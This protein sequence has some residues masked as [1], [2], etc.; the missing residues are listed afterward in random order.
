MMSGFVVCHVAAEGSQVIATKCADE[1]V[2]ADEGSK[3]L[4]Y[5]CPVLIQSSTNPCTVIMCQQWGG[6]QEADTLR[7]AGDALDEHLGTLAHR[8]LTTSF[9][10][11]ACR[12][13]SPLLSRVG[14]QRPG[15]AQWECLRELPDILDVISLTSKRLI[16]A[17]ACV[18]QRH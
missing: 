5:E 18:Q 13:G 2:P 15:G 11:I 1:L 7:Q 9:C 6:S 17:C 10:R 4:H 3:W 16:W 14:L 12:R 8:H